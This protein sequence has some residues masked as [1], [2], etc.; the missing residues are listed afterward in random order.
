MCVCPWRWVGLRMGLAWWAGLTLGGGCGLG[1]SR[2]EGGGVG[3]GGRW[4]WLLSWGGLVRFG[5]SKRT[6]SCVLSV[7]DIWETTFEVSLSSLKSCLKCS[8]GLQLC[9]LA[10]LPVSEAGPCR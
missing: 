9:I 8:Q 5:A 6:I 10:L 2:V 1:N 3:I 7:L 4:D